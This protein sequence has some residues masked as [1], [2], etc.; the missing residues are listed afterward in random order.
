MRVFLSIEN[1]GNHKVEKG[2]DL[3]IAAIVRIAKKNGPT[4]IGSD[5]AAA[6]AKYAEDI[7]RLAT[8]ANRLTIHA[9]RKTIREVDVNL[10]ALSL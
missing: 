9:G 2:A 1:H 7:G 5:G 10:A 4:R 6:F 8:E 3:P